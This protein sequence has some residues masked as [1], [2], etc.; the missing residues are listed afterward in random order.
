MHTLGYKKRER[1]V[2]G[3]AVPLSARVHWFCRPAHS[4]LYAQAKQL[5]KGDHRNGHF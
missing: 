4:R 3:R 1:F 5:Q 2:Q